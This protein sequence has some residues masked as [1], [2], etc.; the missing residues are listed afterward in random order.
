MARHSISHH[1]GLV[2]GQRVEMSEYGIRVKFA[3]TKPRG[4]HLDGVKRGEVKGF[5]LASVRR[6]RELLLTKYIPSAT[7]VGITLTVPWKDVAGDSC[8]LFR[9]AVERFRKAFQRKYPH[10]AMIYRVELQKRGMPHLHAVC[11]FAEGDTFDATWFT[12]AW[13]KQGFG[14]LY[15][16]SMGADLAHGVKCEMMGNNCTRLVQYLCDHASKKKQAQLGW[17]GRQ[18]GVFAPKNLVSRPSTKLPPFPTPRAEGYFWRLIHR[19]TRYRVK[20]RGNCPFGYRYTHPRRV[21]GVTF[22]VSPDF[23]NRCYDLALKH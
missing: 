19:F 9:A 20:G 13:W 8:R 11:Y 10:S 23:V 5:S 18:W 3:G 22:G 6:L 7:V 17:E 14:S 1:F 12:F 15:D 2:Q 4:N 16:G 21:Y